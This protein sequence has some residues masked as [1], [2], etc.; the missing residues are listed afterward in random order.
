MLTARARSGEPG[1]TSA[2]LLI[3]RM[4]SIRTFIAEVV[5]VEQISPV[6]RQITVGGGD[7]VEFQPLAPDQFVY[8][9][10]AGLPVL[11]LL[12][13]SRFAYPHVMNRYFGGAKS[14]LAVVLPV[15]AARLRGWQAA[16]FAGLRT[17]AK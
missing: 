6:M 13:I 7:L 11:G 3:A 2:E 4:R 15:L 9:L 12:M 10:A 8:V 1:Q 5:R 16:R 14:P 17:L